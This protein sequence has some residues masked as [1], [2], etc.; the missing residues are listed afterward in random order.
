MIIN[1]NKEKEIAYIKQRI[2]DEHRKHQ[3][4]DWPE[5]AAR[6]IYAAHMTERNK[7]MEQFEEII[8]GDLGE[9]DLINELH[10]LDSKRKNIEQ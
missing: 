1:M 8:Y 5:I 10:K 3:R 7:W 6:K 2:I 4:L 9:S